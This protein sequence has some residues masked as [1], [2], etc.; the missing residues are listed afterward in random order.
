MELTKEALIERFNKP[1]TGHDRLDKA[2]EAV[3][4]GRVKKHIFEPS[5][6]VLYTVVGRSGDEFVDPGK[7]FCSCESFF[8]SVLGGKYESCY[9]LLAHRIANETGGFSE[10]RFHD[11]EFRNFLRLLS[12]DLLDRSGDKEDKHSRDPSGIVPR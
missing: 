1:D 7:P 11:E 2:V 12:M 8:F 10:S 6:R 9:H 4:E 5:G 3:L